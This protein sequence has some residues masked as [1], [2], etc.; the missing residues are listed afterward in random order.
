MLTRAEADAIAIHAAGYPQHDGAARAKL[1]AVAARK[2]ER[3]AEDFRAF[4]AI[5][6]AE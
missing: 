1:R 6:Q 2:H 4:A 5:D 3:E